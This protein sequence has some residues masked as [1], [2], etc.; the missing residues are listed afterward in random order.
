MS[1]RQ[2]MARGAEALLWKSEYGQLIKERIKK[3]YRI[4][5]ID[6]PLRLERTIHEA[7][8]LGEARRAGVATPQI[9]EVDKKGCRVVM[10]FVS[11][12]RLKELINSEITDSKRAEL[13]EQIGRAVGRLHAAGIVHGDLTTS[14]MIHKGGTI[15]FIDFGLGVFSSR[16]EDLGTDLAVLK[17][18]LRSTH[19]KWLNLLWQSFIKGYAQTNPQTQKVLKVLADIERRVRYAKRV[20]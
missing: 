12:E 9:L 16:L 8:L 13:A 18:A 3:G 17:G 6:L 15:Y 11:G 19:F 5:Q 2:L 7:R 14:N 20:D 4:E 1:E 10:E